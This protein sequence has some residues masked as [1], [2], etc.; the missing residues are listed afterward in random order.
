[1]PPKIATSRGLIKLSSLRA[2]RRG[3]FRTKTAPGPVTTQAVVEGELEQ[4]REE[5]QREDALLIEQKKIQ[6]SRRQARER[7]QLALKLQRDAEPSILGSV[8]Q[9]FGLFT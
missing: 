5:Q 1:M 6:E 9:L 8:L 3:A 2:L 7:T 4:Q